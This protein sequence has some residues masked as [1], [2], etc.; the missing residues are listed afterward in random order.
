MSDMI[1]MQLFLKVEKFIILTFPS[2]PAVSKIRK[3]ACKD[4][5][6]QSDYLQMN[7]PSSLSIAQMASSV[8]ERGSIFQEPTPRGSINVYSGI[9]LFLPT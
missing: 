3:S 6:D 1:S 2:S 4:F 5:L 7:V 9:S 8:D